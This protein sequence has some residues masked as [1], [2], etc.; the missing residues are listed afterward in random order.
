[1][2]RKHMKKHAEL[3]FEILVLFNR[4]PTQHERHFSYPD[5]TETLFIINST[6]HGLAVS[7]FTQPPYALILV[8]AVVNYTPTLR[9]DAMFYP[10]VL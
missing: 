2:G 3:A 1:M 10:I 4:A 5:T 9:S 7:R 8:R 6:A